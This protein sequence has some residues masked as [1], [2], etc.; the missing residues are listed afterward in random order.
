MD[1]WTLNE[2]IAFGRAGKKV[3][4]QPRMDAY[5]SDRDF[6]KEALP[7]PY[8]GLDMAGVYRA[9]GVSARLYN[10]GNPAIICRDDPRVR[11]THERLDP[12]TTKTTTVTPVGT[13]TRVDRGN[14][15]NYGEMPLKWPVETV[16]D[17]QIAG[18]L[19]DHQT[20]HFDQAIYDAGV[21]E[22]GDLGAPACFVPRVSVQ[23]LFVNTMGPQEG[24]FMLHDEP[25]ACA[26]YFA[27]LR[28][29]HDRCLEAIFSSPIKLIN[30]GDNIH[31]KI[32]TPSLFEKYVLPEYLHRTDAIRAAGRFSFAHWDGDCAPLLQFAKHCGL[33]GIEAITPAPQGDVT[34][35]Q[36]QEALG[37]VLLIDGVPAIYFDDNWPVATLLGC[38]DEL[39]ERFAGRLIL[40]IS[41][42]I[43][44]RGNLD[45]I[46]VVRDRV[47]EW[48]AAH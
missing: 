8:T 41:D 10:V 33:H 42:E 16:E 46:A 35:D 5:F 38:V 19:A 31:G 9:L 24:L 36:V 20:W 17:L 34:L 23:D 22:W 18:W 28:R 12:M 26:D 7:A 48:N 13:L 14:T 39:L 11:V 43:S 29:C 40:G 3:I 15:S 21:A 44:S 30:F 32:C 25:E 4:W 47:D 45:R 2:D 37:D 27:S 1:L 6:R